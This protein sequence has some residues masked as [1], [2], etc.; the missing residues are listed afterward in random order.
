MLFLTC[1]DTIATSGKCIPYGDGYLMIETHGFAKPEGKTMQ[2]SATKL[3]FN[4]EDLDA[5]LG[6]IRSYGIDAKIDHRFEK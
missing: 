5:A 2:D 1:L 4:V 3:R 6:K